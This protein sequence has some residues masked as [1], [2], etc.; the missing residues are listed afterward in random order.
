L[1]AKRFWE[2]LVDIIRLD[3]FAIAEE[4][5]EPGREWRALS[6]CRTE[7]WPVE[8]GREGGVSANDIVTKFE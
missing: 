6:R 3:I 1:L 4:S 2:S 8:V 5:L 7:T